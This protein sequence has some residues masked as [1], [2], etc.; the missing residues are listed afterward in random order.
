MIYLSGKID[1]FGYVVID[2][3]EIRIV[4]KMRDI[5]GRACKKIIDR[6]YFVT[7]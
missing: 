4:G 6:Y 2:Q 5:I 3:F 1:V 7:F